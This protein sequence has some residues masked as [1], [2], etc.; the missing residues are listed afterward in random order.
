MLPKIKSDLERLEDTASFLFNRV[1]NNGTVNLGVE[2][3][4]QAASDI[5]GA[6]QDIKNL[7]DALTE[8]WSQYHENFKRN[9][10]RNV[11]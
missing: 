3:S 7:R 10:C 2:G 1:Q 4:L 5:R 9:N 8:E 11:N 6:I